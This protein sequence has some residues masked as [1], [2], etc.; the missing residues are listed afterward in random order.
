MSIADIQFIAGA[1]LLLT[2][3]GICIYITIASIRRAWA[4]EVRAAGMKAALEII[5]APTVHDEMESVGDGLAEMMDRIEAGEPAINI[6]HAS[7]YVARAAL[8]RQAKIARAALNEEKT[9]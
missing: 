5:A 1:G 7:H 8:E 3:T 6:D 9:K 4:A 2:G